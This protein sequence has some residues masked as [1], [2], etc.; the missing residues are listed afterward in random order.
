MKALP[1]DLIIVDG[2]ECTL[3]VGNTSTWKANDTHQGVVLYVGF[4]RA[5]I[6]RTS[7][8]WR[9]DMLSF[10]IECNDD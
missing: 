10:T 3:M 9:D 5:L 1:G 2:S 7:G 8:V 4:N 6:S